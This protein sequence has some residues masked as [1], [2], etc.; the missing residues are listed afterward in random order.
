MTSKQTKWNWS[1]K[2]Q[3]AL[4]TIKKLVS[5]ET[6]LSYPNF[7]KLFVIHT[8]VNMLQLGAVATQE[9]NLLPSIVE[10]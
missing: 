10:N 9:I 2:Y 4:Y 5:R 7:N 1:N 6:L 8:D 3:K